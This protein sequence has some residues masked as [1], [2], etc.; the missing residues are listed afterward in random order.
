LQTDAA[1]NPGNS[2]G[3]LVDAHGRIV[4]INT[5]I[6]GDAYQGISF[7]I[8]V[9]EARAVYDRLRSAGRVARGWLGVGLE[10]LAGNNGRKLRATVAQGVL[11]THVLVGAPAEKAGLRAGDVILQWDGHKVDS[12]TT[13]TR[14]VART[15][16][17]STVE[18]VIQR[19]QQ[20][21]TLSVTVE[22]RPSLAN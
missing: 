17:D 8:P 4:G 18:V 9:N 19:G 12:K 6:Y 20:T 1:V 3:P 21:M 11:I 7:A 22:E 5:A 16:I 13:L 2:G 15:K 14:L 10:E